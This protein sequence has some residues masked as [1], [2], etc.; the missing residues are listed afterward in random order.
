MNGGSHRSGLL[1]RVTFLQVFLQVLLG[2]GATTEHILITDPVQP[3]RTRPTLTT[4]C[5]GSRGQGILLLTPP[6]SS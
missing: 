4:H 6:P 5:L 3:I 2:H 1:P